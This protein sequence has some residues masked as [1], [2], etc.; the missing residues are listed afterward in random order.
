M[1][2]DEKDLLTYTP[3]AEDAA[4]FSGALVEA[5]IPHCFDG[6]SFAVDPDEEDKIDGLWD[7]GESGDAEP[8]VGS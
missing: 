7:D 6:E 3:S 2:G 4:E 8:E 5:K 1:S